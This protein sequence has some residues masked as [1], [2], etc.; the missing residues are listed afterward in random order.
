MESPGNKTLL[1]GER[2]ILLLEC[3]REEKLTSYLLWIVITD[4]GVLIIIWFDMING[5]PA[6][7]S[8]PSFGTTKAV[9]CSGGISSQCKYILISP[10]IGRYDYPSA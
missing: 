9:K 10:I 5:I 1:I 6:K 7:I 2:M 8:Q 4:F 3:P